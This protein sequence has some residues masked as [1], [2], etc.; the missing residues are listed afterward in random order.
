MTLKKT[1]G[2]PLIVDQ[3]QMKQIANDRNGIPGRQIN[4][5]KIFGELIKTNNKKNQAVKRD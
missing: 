2:D 4:Q 1:E 3:G 5:N